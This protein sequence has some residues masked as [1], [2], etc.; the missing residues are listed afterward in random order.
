MHHQ[1]AYRVAA[2]LALPSYVFAVH[3]LTYGPFELGLIA[4]LCPPL[5]LP[6]AI[7]FIARKMR[8][9]SLFLAVLIGQIVI[10]VITLQLGFASPHDDF[11][12]LI[13][14]FIPII[15]FGILALVLMVVGFL[16]LINR[17]RLP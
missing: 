13:L 16:K 14:A 10:G 6:L 11:R 15:Q 12:Y 17:Q 9:Q 7:V 2:A 1:M 8:T 3:W 4:L 5:V